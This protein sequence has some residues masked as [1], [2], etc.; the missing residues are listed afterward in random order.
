MILSITI[1]PNNLSIGVLSCLYRYAHLEISPA[2]GRNK[3]VKY[4]TDTAEIELDLE[5]EYPKG[6]I[7]NGHLN[8]LTTYAKDPKII[9]KNT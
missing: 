4:P 6:L 1:V 7:N 2:L 3:L 9:D 5:T 8:P